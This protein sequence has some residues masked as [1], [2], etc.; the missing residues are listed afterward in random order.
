MAICGE[1][2]IVTT[3]LADTLL[4]VGGAPQTIEIVYTWL[5]SENNLGLIVNVAEISEDFNDYGNPDIDSTPDNMKVGEDDIDDAAVLLSVR[6]GDTINTTYI[7]LAA[8]A[9][10]LVVTGVVLIKKFVL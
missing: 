4:T 9:I 1:G 2:K 5:N 8:S 10:A 3:Q 6:T 7:I